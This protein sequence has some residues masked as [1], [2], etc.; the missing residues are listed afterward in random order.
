MAR[1]VKLV[2]GGHDAEVLRAWCSCGSKGA[3]STVELDVLLGEATHLWLCLLCVGLGQGSRPGQLAEHE[4][5]ERQ[6]AKVVQHWGGKPAPDADV[7]EKLRDKQL[8]KL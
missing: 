4:G 5:S 8:P 2:H 3:G 7:W 6:R 1:E